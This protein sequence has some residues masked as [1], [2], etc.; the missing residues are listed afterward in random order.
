MSHIDMLCIDIKLLKDRIYS[1]CVLYL[2]LIILILCN[3]I[4]I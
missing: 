4:T 1:D 3:I 2:I